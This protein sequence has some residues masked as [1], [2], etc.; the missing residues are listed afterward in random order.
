MNA[1]LAEFQ[2]REMNVGG[3]RVGVALPVDAR[4]L[5][6]PVFSYDGRFLVGEAAVGSVERVE[7]RLEQGLRVDT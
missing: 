7:V 5:E 3:A 1:T 2:V 4:V 6:L